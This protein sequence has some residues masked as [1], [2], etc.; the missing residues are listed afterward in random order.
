MMCRQHNPQCYNHISRYPVVIRQI[1][2]ESPKVQYNYTKATCDISCYIHPECESP[3]VQYNYTKATCDISCYIHPVVIAC[4][5]GQCESP[6]GS[7][8]LVVAS[9]TRLFLGKEGLL[10]TVHACAKLL[11]IFPVKIPIKH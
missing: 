1:Q 11:D 4:C 5:H 3:K 8:Y 9:F 6:K 2:C 10:S 7:V